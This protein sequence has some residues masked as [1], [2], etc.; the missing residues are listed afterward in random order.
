MLK[1]FNIFWSYDIRW[2]LLKLSK[3]LG[4]NLY[5][6]LFS[7]KGLS[8][9]YHKLIF[10]LIFIEKALKKKKILAQNLLDQ[11]KFL[12]KSVKCLASAPG[13]GSTFVR[14]ML[15]SYFEL[16][17]KTGNGIPK[18]DNINNDWLYSGS[19]IIHSDLFNQIDLD[20]PTKRENYSYKFFSKKEYFKNAI[21][22]TRYPFERIDLHDFKNLKFIVLFREPYDW[23]VSY[24]VH[25]EKRKF[26]TKK[27]INEKLIKHS[28]L[29]L[30]KYY[31]F[32]INLSNG[33]KNK[34]LFL[35]Y[36]KSTTKSMNSFAKICK[37]Y[38]L[39]VS[40]RKI[41]KDCVKFNS[42]KFSLKTI[43]Y[44]FEGTRYTNENKKK[45]N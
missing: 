37:F 40:E 11:Q 45:K 4:I 16:Y 26:L 29:R 28:L 20:F 9:Y 1:R 10:S 42:K 19:P 44:R 41:L 35:D 17:F 2:K 18:F 8:G 24:Y 39:D 25:H 30:K 23:M 3:Y 5:P 7:F 36:K 38:D 31:E 13:S 15:K 21:I 33:R 14:C 43:K 6:K 34:I 32:W 12:N 22:F 27:K